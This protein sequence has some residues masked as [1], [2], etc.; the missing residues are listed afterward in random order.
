MQTNRGFDETVSKWLEETAPP[1]VPDRV[2]EA[3]F[4]RT[5]R[6]RQHMGWRG[7]LRWLQVARFASALCGAVVVVAVTGLALGLYVNQIGVGGRPANPFV[8][9]W[10]ATDIDGSH[11]TMEIVHSSA[12]TLEL[13]ILD[14][15]A[16]VCDYQPSTMTGIAEARGVRA[17]VVAQ[18]DYACDDGRRPD[19]LEP[20]LEQQ[21]RNLTFTYDADKDT[22]QDSLGLNWTRMEEGL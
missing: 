17:I 11:Q 18:P 15:S 10:E 16:S 9:S 2:F 8:G 22:L 12:A 14:D 6:T 13:T 1:R 4:E 19:E 3:T 20:P 5:R 7:L 21:L